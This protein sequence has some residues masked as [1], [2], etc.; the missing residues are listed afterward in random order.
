MRL[1]SRSTFRSALFAAGIFAL[2]G[3]GRAHAQACCVSTSALFPARL[4]GNDIAG[5]GVSFSARDVFG[6]FNDMGRFTPSPSST[7]EAD[8]EQRLLAVVQPVH[9]LQ[10]GVAL[11]FDETWR[12]V[13]S[14][15]ETGGGL[16]DASLSAR[17]DFLYAGNEYRIPGIALIGAVTAPTGVAVDRAHRPL[18]TDATGQGLWQGALGAALEYDVNEAIVLELVGQVTGRLSRQ[19]GDVQEQLAP[20]VSIAAAAAYVFE[21]LQVV[22]LLATLTFEGDAWIN[23][24]SV[25][26]SGR[27]TTDVGVFGS[28]P[29][30]DNFSL[31]AT[32]T[33]ELPILELG[34]G[35]TVG[36]TLVGAV[37]KRW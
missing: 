28:V 6:S 20:Q 19:V 23:G 16:G 22:A 37:I 8:F 9:R 4:G 27:R 32:L 35:Q 36:L 31:Q 26:N 29:L 7:F 10:I 13:P 3:A 18:A 30:P 21:G 11:P 15:S 5:F 25:A 1:R 12:S 2:I 14:Q 24:V 17:Y 33:T 34:Q